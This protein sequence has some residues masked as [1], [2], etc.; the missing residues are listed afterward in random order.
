MPQ[1]AVWAPEKKDKLNKAH[2]VTDLKTLVM[3]RAALLRET[4]TLPQWQSATT[5]SGYHRWWCVK[6]K[7]IV[8]T[9]HKFS[10]KLCLQKK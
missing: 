10:T 2:T 9:A 1:V 3:L 5:V 7:M 8:I 6:N 4:T